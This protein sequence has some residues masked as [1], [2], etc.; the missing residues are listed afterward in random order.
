VFVADGDVLHPTELARG[1]WDPTLLHGGPL[2]GALAWAV[3]RQLHR[4]PPQHPMRVAR[5]TIDLLRPVPMAPLETAAV[6]VKKGRQIQVID[7]TIT[8]EGKVV[9]RASAVVVRC[10][11]EVAVDDERNRA[12]QGPL[13]V[14]RHSGAVDFF[15]G[16]D[17]SDRP[18]GFV[19][20]LEMVRTRGT[21]RAGAP[22]E[23][24][25]RFRA[26]LVAGEATTPLQRV[27][28][29]GDF[30][31]IAGTYLSMEQYVSPNVDNS[32]HLFREPMGE[33]IGIEGATVVAPD[34]IAQSSGHIFD[35]LGHVG[36]NQ[37]SLVVSPRG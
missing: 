8:H 20:A 16:V 18:T 4:D 24:W 31:T 28:A 15:D 7:A 5:L 11:R 1:P 21:W 36:Q 30:T 25:V 26:P 33:W 10:D 3:Q 13:P 23:V 19:D 27:A 35:D 17:R 32:Y 14:G 37:T 6:A 34:G 12:A 22:A 29:L 2:A 9:S